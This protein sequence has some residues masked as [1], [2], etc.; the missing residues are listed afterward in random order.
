VLRRPIWRSTGML[1]A[2]RDMSALRS[3]GINIWLLKQDCQL[4]QRWI[5]RTRVRLAARRRGLF[6][7][8]MRRHDRASQIPPRR[9]SA[10]GRNVHVRR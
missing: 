6:R 10:S 4:R 9:W 3:S 1:T 2:R 5:R 7:R 8:R